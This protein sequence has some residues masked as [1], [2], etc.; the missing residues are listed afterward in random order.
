MWCLLASMTILTSWTSITLKNMERCAG[1]MFM[2]CQMALFHN[3]VHWAYI[4]SVE[5]LLLT[6]D[7][8]PS[9]MIIY[10]IWMLPNCTFIDPQSEYTLLTVLHYYCV[11]VQRCRP[12]C[13]Q[14]GKI[15]ITAGMYVCCDCSLKVEQI[16]NLAAL[17][18]VCALPKDVEWTEKQQDAVWHPMC[19]FTWTGLHSDL[20]QE[21]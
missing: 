6:W 17:R 2:L 18:C 3:E 11:Y 12:S 15:I 19:D 21:L 4:S 5:F 13:L 10:W 9:C 8:L 1:C 7:E 14:A 16:D 20:R